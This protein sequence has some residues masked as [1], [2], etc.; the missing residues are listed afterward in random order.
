M[1]EGPIFKLDQNGI[2]RNLLS[3]PTDFLKLRKQK[4][5]LNGQ[6]SPWFNIET[7]VPQGSILDNNLS[8]GFTTN[9]DDVLCRRCFTFFLVDYINL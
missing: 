1:E 6:L 5:V 9:P 4:V 8:D 2:S 7:G 3:T